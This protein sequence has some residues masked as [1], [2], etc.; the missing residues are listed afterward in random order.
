MT[1]DENELDEKQVYLLVY[2]KYAL[3]IQHTWRLSLKKGAA[4]VLTAV[5]KFPHTTIPD[6]P[7]EGKSSF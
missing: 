7:D 5:S 4:T 1:L 3:I 6:F 2:I